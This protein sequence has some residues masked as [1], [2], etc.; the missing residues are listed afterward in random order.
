M[1]QDELDELAGHFRK[2]DEMHIADSIANGTL[3]IFAVSELQGRAH[4]IL[5]A[6]Q[7]VD[8]FMAA[9]QKRQL[10]KPVKAE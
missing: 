3:P 9:A 5:A 4:K 1:T 6:C 2:L 8:D 10:R 7:K